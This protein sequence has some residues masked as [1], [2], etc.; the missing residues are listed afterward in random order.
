MEPDKLDSLFRTE[1]ENSS[2]IPKN[3]DWDKEKAWNKFQFKTKKRKIKRRIYY[4][5]AIT[6]IGIATFLYPYKNLQNE[7]NYSHYETNF[8][9]TQKREKLKEIEMG[10]SGKK[11]YRNYC[12]YC[13]EILPIENKIK[14]NQTIFTN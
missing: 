1:F 2:E 8:V 12:F 10:I 6:I 4:S 3:I 13:D 7:S 14:N 5:A 9:E 11:I